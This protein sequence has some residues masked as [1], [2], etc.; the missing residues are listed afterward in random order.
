MTPWWSVGKHADDNDDTP[1]HDEDDLHD[2]YDDEAQQPAHPPMPPGWSFTITPPPQTQQDPREARDEERRR[3]IR[4]WLGYHGASAAIGWFSGLGGVAQGFLDDMGASAPAA[5]LF[6]AFV[7]YCVGE[8]ALSRVRFI[9]LPMRPAA[10]LIARIPFATVVL[11][12]A[13]HAPNAL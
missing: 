3:R 2:T 7:A 12:L 5:G 4:I 6:M 9:P 10:R 11:A 8:N 1:P 13:L